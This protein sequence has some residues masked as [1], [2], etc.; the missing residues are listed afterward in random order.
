MGG[1]CCFC[2]WSP[3]RS[4]HHHH[5]HNHTTT[6]AS[7]PPTPPHPL[8]RP[9]HLT[10]SLG[11]EGFGPPCVAG[12]HAS[13]TGR[14]VCSSVSCS[15][16]GGLRTPPPPRPRPTPSPPNMPSINLQSPGSALRFLFP[17]TQPIHKYYL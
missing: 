7:L 4:S 10:L 13:L 8:A 9:A 5:H 6:P 15:S 11:C 17:A 1:G 16:R 14:L 12:C 2:R 3:S